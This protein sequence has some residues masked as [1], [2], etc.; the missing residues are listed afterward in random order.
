MSVTSKIN[1]LNTSITKED[2]LSLLNKLA[3]D[4]TLIAP[5][6]APDLEDV[7]FLPVSDAAAICFDYDNTTT[8]PKEF[9]FPQYERM[10]SFSDASSESILV[11]DRSEEIILFGVRSCDVKGIELLDKFYR[12]TFEDNYYLAKRAHSV[13]ISVACRGLNEQCFCTSTRT[14]PVLEEGFDVQLLEIEGG[15]AAQIGSQKGLE[16]YENYR[17][18]F[19]PAVK[20]DIDNFCR[21]A[22]NSERKFDIERVYSNLKL[23]KVPES[24]WEDV[25]QRCQSCGLCLFLCPTCSCYTVTDT[26]TVSGDH[27]RMRQWDGCYFAGFTRMSGGNNPT[28]TGEQMARRKYEHKLVQ[29][30]DEFGMCGCTGCGRCNLACVGNVNWLESIIKIERAKVRV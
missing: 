25:A 28:R 5:Q 1:V 30:I 16:L 9:F 27:C 18:Y 4:R 14:G 7:N 26:V 23:N 12:R 8:S 2:L 6:R 22:E 29:Q 10:F 24:L 13:I 3:K 19:G 17:S 20:I 21:Q 11:T 15:Y